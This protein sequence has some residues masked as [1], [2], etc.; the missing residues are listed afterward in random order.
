MIP[1]VLL[2]LPPSAVPLT[3]ESSTMSVFFGLVQGEHRCRLSGMAVE[4]CR[5][6]H[7]RLW[8]AHAQNDVMIKWLPICIGANVRN[9]D[10][11]DRKW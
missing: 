9:V 7:W 2:A 8:N 3:L 11:G 6:H 5:P 4:K 1:R 10:K